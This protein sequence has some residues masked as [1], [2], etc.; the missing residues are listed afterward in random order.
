MKL[1]YVASDQRVPG[2][3]GGSV[4]VE[5]V[6]R[7]LAV[8]GHQ[9]HVLAVPGEGRTNGSTRN[10]E[11]HPSR[12]PFGHRLFRWTARRDVGRLLDAL[13]IDAVMERYY[14]FGGE[15]VRAAFDRGVPSLLEVNSPLRD[16]PGSLKSALDAAL[17][18]RPMKRLRSE[19]CRKAD[20]LVTP[21]PEIVPDEVP[22]EKVHRVNWGANVERF[23]PEVEGKRLEIPEGRRVVV[24]SGSFRPWHGADLLMRAAARVLRNVPEAFFL[25]LGGGPAWEDTRALAAKLGIEGGV[26]FTGAVSYEEMPAHLKGARVGVAPYQP[27]RLG[28]M[29][30]GFYWS[31]LKVFEYMAM[32]LPVVTLDTPAL[33][34]IVRPEREGLLVPEAD[35]VALARA[36]ENLL[37]DPDSAR[38]MGEAARDRV[39]AQF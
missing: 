2:R 7:G 22:R 6:A 24:F 12:I 10:Y 4:H 3:T 29:R 5:E 1:L 16:H 39:V 15:G 25:F 36:I 13:G 33:A 9:V 19:L 35:E 18:V 21:L 28:Q 37:G 23:R 17:L 20:A 26:L 32:A 30:L 34:E 27:S 11:L 31:P 8:L 14:N 38:A